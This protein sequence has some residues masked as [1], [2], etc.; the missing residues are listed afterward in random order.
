MDDGKLDVNQYSEMLVRMVV[1]GG[2]LS[3][4]SRNFS[5]ILGGVSHG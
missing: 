5:P 4:Q 2:S 1:R 3:V